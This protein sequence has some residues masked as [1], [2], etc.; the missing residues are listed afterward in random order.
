MRC[1]IIF[2]NL[3]S[4]D[5]YLTHK[6]L[7]DFNNEITN[8]LGRGYYLEIIPNTILFYHNQELK[9]FFSKELSVKIQ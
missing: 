7:R 8:F 6:I 9:L 4:S 2:T 5:D 3:T 1:Q